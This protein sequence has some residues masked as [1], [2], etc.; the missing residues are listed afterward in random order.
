MRNFHRSEK[1]FP[2]GNF[3][4]ILLATS[5]FLAGCNLPQA[6]GSG[7]VSNSQRQTEI[8][9]ILNPEGLPTGTQNATAQT[10]Q[11]PSENEIR[12][13]FIHYVTQQG[14]TLPSLAAR[15]GV[16]VSGIQTDQ[17]LPP[18]GLLPPGLPLWIP[19][20]L[21]ETLPYPAAFFP[22]SAVIYGPS[23]G[24]FNAADFAVAAGGFLAGYSE[25]VND[26]PMTGPDIV[27]TIAVETSTNPRLLLALLEHRSG[28]VFGFPEGAD[29]DPYPLGFGAG[30]DTGLYKELM[31][32]ARLLAQGFYGWRAGTLLAL[33]YPESAD[34]RLTP[35]LNA[36]S[37]ALMNLF[38]TFFPQTEWDIALF[39]AVGF[40]NAYTDIFGDPWAEAA[41]VEPYLPAETQQPDLTLPFPVGELWSLT[42]GPHITWQTGT[43]RGA[44]DFAPIIQEAICAVSVR[45]ATAAAPGLVVRSDRGVVAL[46]LD[47]DGD[48][49]TGW[50][51]IY[52]HIAAE[53]RAAAGTW[54]AQDAPI[55]HPSCEGG[56][57]TGT[58]VHL[59]RK[60]NGE[61]VGV[62]DPLPLVLSGWRAVAGEKNYEGYLVNGG[63]VVNASPTGL[64]GSVIS[65]EE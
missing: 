24:D 47:G 45:W 4:I 46:D 14:D 53:E 38:A 65:R 50:V 22:D 17:A 10:T 19:D 29:S 3:I 52:L 1:S 43:P 40:L 49:G 60:F 63:N 36:G 54:L 30:A 11:Q 56:S 31:I 20:T 57:A 2:F 12:P 48:E 64:T 9:G 41:L 8:A 32:A 61:W 39:G 6:A 27:Q 59:A 7:Y 28:W 23:V 62:G 55:G 42:G 58:H 16:P 33:P 51:L 34:T 37:V 25:T 5:L 21:E 15:F 13:G 26:V 44:V 18:T 35:T